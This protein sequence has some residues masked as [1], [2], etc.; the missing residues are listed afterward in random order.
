VQVDYNAKTEYD[1]INNY[2]VVQDVFN[3]L[4]IDKHIE[5]QKLVKARPLDNMEFMQWFKSYFDNQ[6]S[7]QGVPDYE[8]APRRALCKSGGQRC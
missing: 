8:G 2:M 7:G 3:K 4:N 6:T 1:Y 5:V